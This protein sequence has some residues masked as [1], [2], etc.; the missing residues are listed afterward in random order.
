MVP[1]LR[2]REA[3]DLRPK[4]TQQASQGELHLGRLKQIFAAHEV[5]DAEMHIVYQ[6]GQLIT[7]LPVA[8]AN[9]EVIVPVSMGVS[10]PSAFRQM[11]ISA[12][13]A[14]RQMLSRPAQLHAPNRVRAVQFKP[15]RTTSAWVAV[16]ASLQ[17][18]RF[19]P[20]K[21]VASATGAGINQVCLSQQAQ[22]P[23]VVAEVLRLTVSGLPQLP[24]GVAEKAHQLPPQVLQILLAYPTSVEVVD[25]KQEPP[26]KVSGPCGGQY[27]IERVA[28]M[29]VAA[30]RWSYP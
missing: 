29:H 16:N 21:H 28:G 8:A 10:C 15:L 2:G 20:R 11:L 6:T 26:L 1:A 30:G 13:A 5:R 7:H 19:L 23:T 3:V 24:S 14:L 18:Q 9:D 12:L 25:A 4:R 17:T 27:E 22:H